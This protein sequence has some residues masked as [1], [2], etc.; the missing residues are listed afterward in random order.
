M[1][2]LVSFG[3]LMGKLTGLKK[4]NINTYYSRSLSLN[5][6]S[7]ALLYFVPDPRTSNLNLMN[8]F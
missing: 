7:Q 3:D 5:L 4:Q 1:D 2:L 6:F 8:I